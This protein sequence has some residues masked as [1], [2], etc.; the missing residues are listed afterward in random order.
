MRQYRKPWLNDFQFILLTEDMLC[1]ADL[2]SLIPHHWIFMKV[3]LTEDM[4]SLSGCEEADFIKIESL[5][6]PTIG[7]L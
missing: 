2:T 5:S 1:L 7:F 6:F 3:L 4:L